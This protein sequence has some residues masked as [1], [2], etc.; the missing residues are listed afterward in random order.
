[1]KRLIRKITFYPREFVL[2]L[3]ADFFDVLDNFVCL[4]L[5]LHK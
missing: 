5:E 2:K 1:M 4:I 3:L